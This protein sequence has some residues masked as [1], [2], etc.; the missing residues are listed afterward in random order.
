MPRR[1]S[2]SRVEAKRREAIFRRI[3]VPLDGS[4]LAAR[5]LS[6]VA[7]ILERN[8][9][10]EVVLL[11]VLPPGARTESCALALEGIA[12]ELRELEIKVRTELVH[13]D[14]AEQIE[15]AAL[16]TRATLVAM[17]THGRTGLSRVARGSTAESILRRSSLPMLLVNPFE[18]DAAWRGGFAK[19]VACLDG[20][21]SST[22]VLP[23]AS[24]FARVF[25]AEVVL[26]SVVELP[27]VEPLLT[28]VM[29]STEDIQKTLESYRTR[30]EG[31]PTRVSA[32]IG[33][34]GES[35]LGVATA[36]DVGL[37]ALTT[38]GRSGFDRLARGS[39]AEGVLR[40][41]ACPVLVLRRDDP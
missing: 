20:S 17:A 30:I 10:E 11:Q 7:E 13:G 35:I 28:P 21:E 22:A 1:N 41:S 19:V 16:R 23:A 27:R 33:W 3:L 37:L 32:E 12:D 34:P 18:R 36:G 31:V 5:I 26:H 38:H 40:R 6:R 2:H 9:S 29:L 4:E 39:V 15:A 8:A 24:A 25:G 14:P